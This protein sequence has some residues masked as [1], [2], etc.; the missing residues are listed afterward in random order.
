MAGDETD[1]QIV[2]QGRDY[3]A[4]TYEGRIFKTADGKVWRE[5][6]GPHQISTGQ[7]QG[8]KTGN[9]IIPLT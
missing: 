6:Y 2:W 3:N 1:T 9:Q 5:T 4:R 8:V 7:I